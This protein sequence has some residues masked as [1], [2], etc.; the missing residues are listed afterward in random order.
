MYNSLIQFKKADHQVSET[1]HWQPSSMQVNFIICD[2]T[3]TTSYFIMIAG[4]VVP[5]IAALAVARVD[6]ATADPT[7]AALF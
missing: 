1:C 2:L 6:V 3:L 7:F 5:A 4:V